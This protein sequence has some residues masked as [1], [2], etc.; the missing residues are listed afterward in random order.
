MD[1]PES[2]TTGH[3][4]S[5]RQQHVAA[6]LNNGEQADRGRSQARSAAEDLVARR[7]RVLNKKMVN[8]ASQSTEACTSDRYASII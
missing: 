2:Q 7:L 3:S 6:T 4:V 8:T 1:S 5:P